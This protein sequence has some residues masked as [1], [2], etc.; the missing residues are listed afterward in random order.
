MTLVD[1]ELKWFLVSIRILFCFQFEVEKVPAEISLSATMLYTYS[2][3][4]LAQN[5]REK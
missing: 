2:G 4:K 3:F 5:F 1:K